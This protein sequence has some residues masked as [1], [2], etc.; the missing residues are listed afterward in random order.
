MSGEIGKLYRL[1]FERRA[2]YLYAHVEGEH[3]SYA[4]SKAYWQEVADECDR[5]GCDAVLIDENIKE[6]ASIADVFQLCSEIPSMG[7]LGVRVA[8]V[9]RYLDHNEVNEFGE[10]V[11]LNRGIDGKLFN[12]IDEAEKWLL[13]KIRPA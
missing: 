8:F 11:A 2:G 1:E 3:D 13:D 10:L 6:A 12:D 9:D 4:I 7:F 5:S